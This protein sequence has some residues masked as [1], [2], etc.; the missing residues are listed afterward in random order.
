[1]DSLGDD[2]ELPEELAV[3]VA[4]MRR[5]ADRMTQILAD[6]IELTRLESAEP[7]ARQEFVDVASLLERIVDE[8]ARLAEG[9]T[10]ELHLETDRAL[11]GNEVELHS[12]FYNLIHNAVRFTPPPGRIDVR[13]RASGDGAELSDEVRGLGIPH[14]QNPRVTR[15]LLRDRPRR[16]RAPRVPGLG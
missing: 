4:E 5:Q 11:L 7:S 3:P 15:R 12:V 2:G 9:R 16:P 14:D 1:L 10:L 13:W 8:L 6:L